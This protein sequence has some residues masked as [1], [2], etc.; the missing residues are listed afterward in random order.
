MSEWGLALVGAGSALAG[1]V[2]TGWFARS[3]GARQ[4]AAARHAGERQAEAAR[5]A[6]ERQADALLDTVRTTLDEQRTVR[7]MEIRRQTYVQ[8]LEAAEIVLL[9]H[10]TGAGSATD[11][12]TLQRAFGAVQLE[13]PADVVRTARELVEGLRAGRPFDDLERARMS[14]VEAA[15]VALGRV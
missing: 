4:A 2:I 8:F 6:G 10:R 3:A 13:G 9:S 11:F 12:P 5:H 15:R 1:G 7:V 14:F